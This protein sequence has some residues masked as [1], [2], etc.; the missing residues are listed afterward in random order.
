MLRCA[1]LDDYQHAALKYADWSAIRARAD[2]T[3]FHDPIESHA[4][5]IRTLNPFDIV[6]IMRERTH[7]PAPVLQALPNLKLLVTAG[8]RNF[9]V[10]MDAAK[11]QGITICGT[12]YGS[13]QT[14]DLTFGLILEFLRRIGEENIRLKTG[15]HWQR[16]IVGRGLSGM[17]LGVLGLG[18]LGGHVARIAQAFGMRVIAWSVNLTAERCAELGV[19]YVTREQLFAQADIITIHLVLSARTQGLVGADEFARMKPDAFIVNT[20]RGPIIDENALREALQAKRIGGAALDVFWQEPLA[21]DHW[22]RRCD[23]AVITPHIGYVTDDNFQVF[24]PE[25]AES[26]TAWLNGA[27]IRVLNP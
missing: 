13:V 8:L 27:P 16:P 21:R 22:L 15:G 25:M 4:E 26:V 2:I 23:N 7:F 20:S 14:A 18:R 5:L 9:A 10:D 17:T 6:C 11:A 12:N 24:Y 1:I 3:V 19:T